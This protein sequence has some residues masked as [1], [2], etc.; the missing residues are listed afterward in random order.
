M[1]GGVLDWDSND[2]GTIVG[3][4]SSANLVVTFDPSTGR[5]TITVSN[6]SANGLFDNAVFYLLDSGKG[7][8]LD[9]TT[10]ASNRALAGS[11]RRQTGGGSF[12]LSTL[13]NNMIVRSGGTSRAD[14]G[15]LDG[16]FSVGSNN[17]YALTLDSR[18]P[19]L[20]DVVNQ[21]ASGIQISSIDSTTG[22]GKVTIPGPTFNLSEV[23]Y[24]VGPNQFVFMDMTPPPNNS[25]APIVFFDPQ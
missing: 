18:V 6:G 7:F 22:R 9:A 17:T 21:T 13:S 19:G 4:T 23:I 20:A 25:A 14:A 3:P 8:I 1:T 5:G 12:G 16:V 2:A 15:T 24:F 10:G 11:F